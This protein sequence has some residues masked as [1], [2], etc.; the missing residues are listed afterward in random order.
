MKKR[1]YFI[2]PA[3]LL[4]AAELYI[5]IYVHDGFIRPYFGDVLVVIL[6]YAIIRIIFPDGKYLLSLGIF[7]F[8]VLVELS[9]IP[10]LVDLLGIENR[11][12]RI[13]MGTS[14]AWEDLLCYAAGTVPTAICDCF[15]YCRKQKIDRS[16]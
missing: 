16:R 14:F 1:L 12:I 10:P 4:F 8:A 5:G 9:Q 13:L 3:V 11:L 7:V 6:I 2:I 15:M